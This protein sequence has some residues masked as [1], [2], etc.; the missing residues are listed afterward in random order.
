MVASQVQTHQRGF[1]QSRGSEARTGYMLVPT[2]LATQRT[3]GGNAGELRLGG[4]A[5]TPAVRPV[6]RR[7]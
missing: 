4:E 1:H 2:W 7:R 6:T 5:A 3:V